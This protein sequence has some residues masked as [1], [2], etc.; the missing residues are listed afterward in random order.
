[1]LF[2][3]RKD[4]VTYRKP[5]YSEILKGVVTEDLVEEVDS[6]PEFEVLASFKFRSKGESFGLGSSAPKTQ[7]NAK[8]QGKESR[9]DKDDDDESQNGDGSSS[10]DDGIMIIS[11]H[12]TGEE[13]AD[14]ITNIEAPTQA[15]NDDDDFDTIDEKINA[16]SLDD[17]IQ[18]KEAT[19][20]KNVHDDDDDDDFVITDETESDFEEATVNNT[21]EPDDD[22][23]D[24]EEGK[25]DVE[26]E[27]EK[28]YE[29]TANSLNASTIK[30][31]M[32]LNKESHDEDS[33]SD[34][35]S[36]V[37]SDYGFLGIHKGGICDNPEK[38]LDWDSLTFQ[39]LSTLPRMDDSTTTIEDDNQNP[40]LKDSM[41]DSIQESD[42]ESNSHSSYTAISQDETSSI[43]ELSDSA[44]VNMDL[45][46]EPMIPRWFFNAD[47]DIEDEIVS[48]DDNSDYIISDTEELDYE[49]SRLIP[50]WLFDPSYKAED[51]EKSVEGDFEF[52]DSDLDFKENDPVIPH[53]FYNPCYK[54]KDT[55]ESFD[56]DFEEPNPLI[57]R[58]FFDPNYKIQ[59]LDESFDDDTDYSDYSDYDSESDDDSS[60]AL[61]RW[62]FDKNFKHPDQDEEG[63]SWP[64]QLFMDIQTFIILLCLTT[65]LGFSIGHGKNRKVY[66]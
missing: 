15:S 14:E 45:S 13:K 48:F 51:L 18:D 9:H 29:S 50:Q 8:T 62:L 42:S 33:N 57:P 3:T 41:I 60:I 65:A 49:E 47:E 40:T 64:S 17:E 4:S 35:D 58:W 66:S 25:E 7:E 53:W 54:P 56:D 10:S 11:S 43:D 63:F 5:T 6:E 21:A 55:D 26:S 39:L 23:N 24:D 2:Q 52:I 37:N 59:D 1:M 27:E 36:N 20:D 22:K 32:P 19:V 34:S 38:D 12:K 46:S 16:G 61:P 31:P 28:L 44:D 30:D